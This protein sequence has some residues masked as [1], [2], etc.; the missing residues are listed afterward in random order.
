MPVTIKIEVNQKTKAGKAFLEMI[1]A[2]YKNQPGIKVFNTDD[3]EC[4]EKDTAF[5][6]KI[7]QKTNKKLTKRLLEERNISL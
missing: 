3:S 5:I 7:S 6:E 4:S 1:N 2:V